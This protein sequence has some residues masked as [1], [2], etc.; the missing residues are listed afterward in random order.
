MSKRSEIAAKIRALFSKTIENGCSEAEAAASAA[1]AK[2]LLDVYQLEMSELELEEEGT[3][4]FTTREEALKRGEYPVREKLCWEISKFCEVKAWVTGKKNTVVFFGLA[5]DVDFADW[6]LDTLEQFIK[7]EADRYKLDSMIGQIMDGTDDFTVPP[8]MDLNGFRAGCI[9]RIKERL[10]FETAKRRD[11][12]H[13]DST[14][15]LIVV[16]DQLVKREFSKLG[17]SFG[18]AK[19][20]GNYSSGAGYSAGRAA[21]DRASFGRPVSGGTLRIGKD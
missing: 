12:H 19:M 7:N 6:L 8:K 17:L 4:Q 11:Q 15:A 10:Q 3:T 2:E 16:K 1:K 18:R 9:S 14:N 5:S 21:G 20:R 13:G